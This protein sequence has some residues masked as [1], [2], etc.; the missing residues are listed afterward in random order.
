PTTA[1]VRLIV[2]LPYENATLWIE[3]QQTEQTGSRRVFR[4]PPLA[5]GQIYDYT[6]RATWMENGTKIDRT[7][8]VAVEAGGDYT[9]DFSTPLS[10][11]VGP[12]PRLR[13]APLQNRPSRQ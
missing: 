2:R 8:H 7:K 12:S 3:D 6:F 13:T 1:S 10:E 5:L 11:D 4:S 9:V